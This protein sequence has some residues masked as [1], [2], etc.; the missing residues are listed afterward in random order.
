[1]RIRRR[2]RACLNATARVGI[3][4][5][6]AALLGFVRLS[7]ERARRAVRQDCSFAKNQESRPALL[8]VQCSGA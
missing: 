1:M 5:V 3:G 7:S 8:V 2:C 6:L 4:G